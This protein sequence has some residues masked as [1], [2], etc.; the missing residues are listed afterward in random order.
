MKIQISE[1]QIEEIAEELDSGLKCFYNFRT[2][3][4]KFIIDSNDPWDMTEEE[5]LKLAEIEKNPV[6]FFEIE[7]MDSGTSFLVMEE[8][9]EEVSDEKFRNRLINALNRPKPFR[10]FKFEIDGNSSYRQ[11]WFDFRN[12]KM[13][14]WVKNQIEGFNFYKTE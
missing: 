11:K 4:L 7:R 8:F 6:D 1:M 2:K 10:N 3:K 5:G 12:Q 13:I 9:T 14:D